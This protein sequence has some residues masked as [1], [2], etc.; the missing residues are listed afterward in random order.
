[1]FATGYTRTA[2]FDVKSGSV[3]R[4]AFAVGDWDR[5]GWVVPLGASGAGPGPHAADQ[6]GAWAEG[7]LFPAPYSRAAVEAACG[8]TGD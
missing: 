7:R 4:Y 8:V 3:A 1:M 5:S 2:A 6:Q